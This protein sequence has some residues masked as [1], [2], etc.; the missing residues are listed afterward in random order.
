VLAMPLENLF[1]ELPG[2]I[3]P[4]PCLSRNPG[5]FSE[6]KPGPSHLLGLLPTS[7]AE[8][9]T[10]VQVPVEAGGRNV[11]AICQVII[12][13]DV[14]DQSSGGCGVFGGGQNAEGTFGVKKFTTL[15][16]ALDKSFSD[17]FN[18]KR[19]YLSL[20]EKIL[21]LRRW[22]K[23]YRKHTN[24]SRHCLLKVTLQATSG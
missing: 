21:V 10:Q 7:S 18:G 24:T 22:K 14:L 15:P 8:V 4:T 9:S 16:A 13:V 6:G 20:L 11:S 2:H 19:I 3:P 17:I 12:G 1:Q 23:Q 5:P